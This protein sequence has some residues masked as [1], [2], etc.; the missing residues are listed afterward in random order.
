MGPRPRL[1]RDAGQ[2]MFSLGT[3]RF[4]SLPSPRLVPGSKN[5]QEVAPGRWKD[6]VPTLGQGRF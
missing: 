2:D 5:R 3:G 4:L 6:E 1:W